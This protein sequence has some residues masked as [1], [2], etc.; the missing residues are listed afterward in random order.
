MTRF[1]RLAIVALFVMT[2][3]PDT[4]LAQSVPRYDGPIID[5][6]LHA[7]ASLFADRQYCFPQPCEGAPTK[8]KR[9]DDLKPMTLLAM[10]RHNIVMGVVSGPLDTVLSWA[11]GDRERFRAGVMRPSRVPIAKLEEL[12]RSGR[13]RV[14]GE[15][16]EQYAGIPIDDP[17]LDPL[18][19]MAHR[20][21]IPVQVHVA[22]AGGSADFPSHLG[23][24]LRLVPVLRKYPGLRVYL[25]NAAWPFLEEA[26]ALMYQYRAVY[27]DISTLLHLTPRSV[28]LKYLKGLVDNGLVKRIVF[29]SDQMIWP[30]VIDVAVDA[31][32][33]ADFLTQEH[34]ADIF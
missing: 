29:G 11:E 34:K 5:M 8:A 13:L 17:A 18:F 20:L 22:G 25:E 12:H 26:T 1:P 7:Y 3:S 19:A 16:N 23:N 32:Q 27:A 15:M 28:A 24:P 6:H 4:L 14:L 2:S 30:E 9:A 21:D 10:E 33:S 31:I